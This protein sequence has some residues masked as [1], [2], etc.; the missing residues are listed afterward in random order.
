MVAKL[1]ARI[2]VIFALAT[3]ATAAWA[4]PVPW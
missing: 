1:L 2:V 3:G 4:G